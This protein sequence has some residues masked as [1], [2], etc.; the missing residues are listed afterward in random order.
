M[1][2][3]AANRSNLYGSP[4][5]ARACWVVSRSLWRMPLEIQ[6][7]GYLDKH[8]PIID[9]DYLLRTYLSDI[10]GNAVHICIRLAIVDKAG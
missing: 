9:V 2:P 5:A 1:E 4:I 8:R 10:Q 6:A 7:L 3:S